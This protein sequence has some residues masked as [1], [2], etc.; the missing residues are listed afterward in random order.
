MGNLI[1][2]KTRHLARGPARPGFERGR[3]IF[4][5]KGKGG[6]GKSKGSEISPDTFR[7]KSVARL[8]DAYSMGPTGGL[9]NGLKSTF[10]IEGS[11]LTQVQNN[12]N[13]L[14]ITGVSIE[15]RLGTPDQDHV[16]GFATVE[17]ES[18]VDVEFTT[19]SPVIRTIVDL[20]LDR[21]RLKVRWPSMSVIDSSGD[22]RPTWAEFAIDLQPFGGSDTQVVYE[23]FAAKSESPYEREYSIDLP[24]GE[25]PW[26]I[27][28][29]RI[30]QDSSGKRQADTYWSSY[31]GAID[32]KLRYPN[33]AAVF[34]TVDAQQFGGD[35]PGRAYEVAGILCH[36]PAN[37]D[38][39]TRT[40]ATTG[41]GTSGGIWDGTFKMEVSDDPAWI[42]YEILTNKAWGC[43]DEIDPD[44]ID[45]ATLYEISQYNQELLD[46]GKGGLEPRFA[47]NTQITEQSSAYALISAVA[48]AFRGSV[49]WAAGMVTFSQDRPRDPVK[50]FSQ[51][52][53]KDGNFN[54]EGADVLA[55]H[56]TALVTFNDPNNGFKQDVMPYDDPE[57]L[58]KCGYKPVRVA[59]FG[60]TSAARAQRTGRWLIETEKSEGETITFCVT[61]DHAD[62]GPGLVAAI[63][64]PMMADVRYGGKVAAATTNSVTI[65]KAINVVPADEMFISVVL[66]DGSLRHRPLTNPAGM[67]T[68]LTF[69]EALPDT[70][71]ANADWVLSSNQIAPE[72]VRILNVVETEE[73][74]FEITAMTY[75]VTKFARV[76]R[77]P[78]LDAPSY[79]KLPS[80]DIG[81]PQSLSA[82]AY[83]YFAGTTPKVAATLGWTAPSDPRVVRYEI[84]IQRPGDVEYFIFERTSDFTYTLYD[85]SGGDLRFRVRSRDALGRPSPWSV[86]TGYL[87]PLDAKPADVEDFRVSVL[88]DVATL[89]WSSTSDYDLDRY[90][91]KF[92][93][94]LS[95]ASWETAITI[96]PDVE[97]T[98]IDVPARIGTY[99]IKAVDILNNESLNATAV[100]NRSGGLTYFNV[101]ET[102]PQDPGF[103]GDKTDVVYDVGLGG[104]I[105]DTGASSGIYEFDNIID[106]TDVYTSRVSAHI[107]AGGINPNVD[108]F[109][110][111]DVFAVNDWFF[112]D[113]SAWGVEIQISYT[114]TDP[115][116]S[117]ANWSEWEPLI[118]ADYTFRAVRFRALLESNAEGI[119]PLITELAATVDM[120]DLF[121]DFRN[122]TIPDTGYR[123]V[124]DPPFK[125]LKRVS[126]TLLNQQDGDYFEISNEDTTGFDVI[127]KNAGVGV[128]RRGDADGK[129]WGRVIS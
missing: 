47:I 108:F 67:A 100:V 74:E 121:F 26:T 12:D 97:A 3:G 107:V 71:V 109:A 123:F 83:V 57:Q 75:D 36:V 96:D 80:G 30:Y 8:G 98:R 2:I 48:S 31:T 42:L 59:D 78:V 27:T 15:E 81:A 77:K 34:T 49:Y 76:E 41:P 79:V 113:A 103:A 125:S 1:P 61:L 62:V 72:P 39:D 55:E 20:S 24:A 28:C 94:A 9:L 89:R 116:A 56:S 23:K 90:W 19:D 95:G 22:V 37:Y 106:L 118:L 58:A 70:P 33:I 73:H 110:L 25:G 43:G 65:D 101:E 32:A 4:G 35:I 45:V 126:F 66:P 51:V 50:I 91:V 87:A 21:I 46:D 127:C 69:D 16:S 29:R 84:H 17:Y 120:P 124:F 92:S 54:R 119:T 68:V 60:N 99:L 115:T 13:S 88:G 129:G 128:E 44:L 82:S 86:F 104:L 7:S 102:L 38:F 6:G 40:F 122:V 112:A 64:D 85:I 53:V 10:V 11:T 52:N 105:L 111:T 93:S 114:L 63:C 14:N 117:P 5:A 18:I